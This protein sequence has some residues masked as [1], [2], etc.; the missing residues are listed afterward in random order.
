MASA[1]SPKV[2]LADCELLRQAETERAWVNPRRVANRPYFEQ[3][4][5]YSPFALTDPD[6]ARALLTPK[7]ALGIGGNSNDLR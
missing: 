4:V 2:D 3:G 5:I 7:R 1:D 6:A